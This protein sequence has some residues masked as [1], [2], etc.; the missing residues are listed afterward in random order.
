MLSITSM[1][2]PATMGLPVIVLP[3]AAP[4]AEPG[5]ADVPADLPGGMVALGADLARYVVQTILEADVADP[6]RVERERDELFA[7]LEQAIEDLPSDLDPEVFEKAA[8]D[9]RAD[10]AAA[11]PTMEWL[12]IRQAAAR[13]H[14]HA[15]AKASA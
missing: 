8:A 14:R 10:I 4:D 2:D 15:A 3:T 11:V 6:G 5:P 1:A 7:A 12:G 9:V 13:A